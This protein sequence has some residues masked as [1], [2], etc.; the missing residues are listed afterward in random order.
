MV[1]LLAGKPSGRTTLT[2]IDRLLHTRLPKTHDM[3]TKL[4]WAVAGLAPA[5]MFVT[6][7]LM[8]W[9]RVVR[10]KLSRQT[11]AKTMQVP[12]RGE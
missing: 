10:K 3:A 1:F 2:V 5:G 11:Q 6:G 12:V 9:N 7:A 4:T 8:W